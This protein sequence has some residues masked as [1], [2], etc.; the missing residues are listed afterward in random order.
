[1]EVGV[2]VG[3]PPQRACRAGIGIKIPA[4]ASRSGPRISMSIAVF[5]TAVISW[6]FEAPGQAAFRRAASA[7]AWGAAAEVPKNVRKP[8]VVVVTP[9]AAVISGF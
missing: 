1:M 3:P 2:G 5:L 6:E 8:G 4:P 7:P 9:S